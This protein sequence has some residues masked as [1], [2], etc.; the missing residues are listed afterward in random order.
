MHHAELEAENDQRG[1]WFSVQGPHPD[2]A[3]R[4]DLE[5]VHACLESPSQRQ[6]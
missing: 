6:L 3:N 4:N 1:E 5:L 2:R